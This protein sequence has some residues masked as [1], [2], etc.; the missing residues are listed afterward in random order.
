MQLPRDKLAR[1]HRRT[2]AIRVLKD[3]VNAGTAAGGVP[4]AA[5]LRAGRAASAAGAGCHPTA[6]DRIGP[7]RR[8]GRGHPISGGSYV[9]AAAAA[10][11]TG[12]WPVPSK[13]GGGPPTPPSRADGRRPPR[14]RR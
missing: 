2:R 9:G 4:R 8:R 7:G 13:G 10:A 12:T 6:R 5:H 14:A 3:R 11:T 1:A